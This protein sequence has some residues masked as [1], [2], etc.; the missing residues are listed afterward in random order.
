MVLCY[1]RNKHASV[2]PLGDNKFRVTNRFEDTHFAAQVEI[3]VTLPELEITSVRG[4][5]ERCFNK[6]C[7][8]VESLIDKAVGLRVG[9]GLTKLLDSLIGGAQGCPV[10]ATLVFEACD[11][12]ILSLTAEQMAMADT[13]DE[14]QREE[15]LVQMVQMNPRLLN[16]CIAFDENGPLLKGRL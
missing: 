11:A 15:G 4:G 7:E 14:E 16:S 5:F 6:E 10:L 2:L 9:S 12:V 8:K 13:L 3:E 1:T